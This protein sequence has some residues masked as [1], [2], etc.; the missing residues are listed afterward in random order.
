MIAPNI[1]E[2]KKFHLIK[3]NANSILIKDI[4]NVNIKFYYYCII[5][6][7]LYKQIA[8][9]CFLLYNKIRLNRLI[10]GN[11]ITMCILLPN[12]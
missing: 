3:N 2:F 9:I 10:K 5:K 12:K 7:H 11:T 6:F 1:I 4:T 8:L